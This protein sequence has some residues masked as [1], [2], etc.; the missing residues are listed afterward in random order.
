[1][2]RLLTNLFELQRFC[3]NPELQKLID[4]VNEAFPDE[5]LSGEPL[6]WIAAAGEPTPDDSEEKDDWL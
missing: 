4:E 5:E 2:E 1:M 3:R 6:R